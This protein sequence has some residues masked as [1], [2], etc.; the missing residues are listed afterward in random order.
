MKNPFPLIL[1]S[2]LFISSLSSAK[3]LHVAKN[4]N[5]A[6][7][8][9]Q[10]KPFLSISKAAKIAFPGDTIT[11]HSCVYREWI[12]PARGGESDTKRI[13]YR[14]AKGEK[15]E[16]KGSEIV[17]GWKKEKDG[18]WKVVIPN[19]FFG[20]YNPYQDTI[21]GDWFNRQGR[22]HH[23]GELFLNGKSF[24]EKEALAKVL[25]P[26]I[27]PN[28]LDSVGCINTWYCESNAETTTIWANFHKVNPN[29]ELTEISMRRT[30]FYPDKPGVNYLTISGF[31]FSQAATQWA[32]PTAEQVGMISTHWNKGW[33]IENNVISDSKCNGISLG[34]ERG[35]GH[36]V[37]T[38]DKENIKRDGSIHYIEVLFNVLR[39]GWN[40][41]NIG[42]HIVRNNTIF[43]CEQTG[44]CGSMGAAFSTIENNHIYNIWTKRQFSG[45]EIGG[46]KFHA[47]VDTYILKNRIH[48]CGRGLWLDWMAQGTRVSCNLFYNNSMEDLFL[49][50]NHGPFVVDNNIFLSSMAIRTQSEGG[51][52]LHNLIAG[53][54]YMWPEPNRFTPYFLPHSTDVAALTTI[55]SGDDRLYNNI[56][57][58]PGNKTYNN[59]RFIFG[60]EV[61]NNAKLP[62]WI[63]GNSYCNRAKPSVKE[64]NFSNDSTFNPGLLLEEKE[65]NVFLHFSFNP[66]LINQKTQLINTAI[67][68]KAKMPR[69]PFD[70]RD[71][72]VLIID[73]DYFGNKR[74]EG[75]NSAG[76]FV[77]V[78]TEKTVLKVW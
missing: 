69:A 36:N 17:T 53:A 15:V 20:N 42:S 31:Y 7:E 28:T 76:P 67:L 10:L 38:L 21:S 64:T 57:V 12:N 13:T 22:T 54:F 74:T 30:I 41:E 48:N 27:P 33:I 65:P 63:S 40:K 3:E 68:G 32:A 47:A 50:V 66:T 45:A 5:D 11:V 29:K 61:Y 6:G 9:S 39:K 19:S 44:I 78:T 55:L 73:R 1:L 2:L 46:I 58:G 70:N 71:G 75:N 62:V 43:N 8:G 23:T 72:S 18:V 60:S 77:Q 51:A 49:E 25:N 14:A 35:S 52:Y 34:K 59:N 26:V 24:Y 37:W 56:F 16:I 4:G